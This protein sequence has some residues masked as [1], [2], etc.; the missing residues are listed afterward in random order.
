MW[1]GGGIEQEKNKTGRAHGRRQQ[2]G[3]C[4]RGDGGT[5][6]GPVMVEG[7]WTWGGDTQHSA[8]QMCGGIVRLRH[9]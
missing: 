4:Q 1:E 5:Y 9:M 7:D 8:Q 3:D 6:R 2:R